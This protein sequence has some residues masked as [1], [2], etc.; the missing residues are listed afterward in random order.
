M[1]Q[2]VG[3]FSLGRDAEVRYI[4]SGEAVCNLI[5]AFNYGKKGSDGKRPSQWIDASLWGKRAESLAQYLT[6]GSMVYAVISDPHI[7]EYEGKNGKGHKLAGTVSEIE[8][9]GGKRDDAP[10][11][12]QENKP[13][14]NVPAGEYDDDQPF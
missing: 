4:P 12:R 1:A 7:E 9:A 3:V 2:I 5:L 10:A 11:P 6:K 8:F 14:A 13:G